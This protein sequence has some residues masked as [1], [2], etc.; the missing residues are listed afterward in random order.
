M[1]R[2]PKVEV[3]QII[4]FTKHGF[5]DTTILGNHH[6]GTCAL[7]SENPM[8]CAIQGRV[9]QWQAITLAAALCIHVLVHHGPW[10]IIHI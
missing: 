3:H 10:T 8:L 6:V 5:W 1:W 4:Y 9:L 2:F 7:G